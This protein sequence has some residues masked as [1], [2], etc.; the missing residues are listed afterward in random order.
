[1]KKNTLY[2]FLLPV[3]SILLIAAILTSCTKEA[4]EQNIVY[5]SFNRTVT[6]T[7]GT[8]VVDSL[9]INSD[10]YVDFAFGLYKSSAADSAVIAVIGRV[11]NAS[12]VDST[13]NFGSLLL[14]KPL[15][16][17]EVPVA[18]VP[19]KR[20]WY[21]GAFC[22]SKVGT[23]TLGIAGAG[24]KFIPLAVKNNETGKYHY[25]WIRINVS[26]DYVTLKI[27]DGA[28]NFLPEIPVKMGAK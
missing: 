10:N 23:T 11:Q 17:N 22:A 5:K 3:I 21:R 1:M 4:N 16:K 6:S 7:A 26:S 9:D 15:S 28:Y 13:Q 14:S 8:F 24:D 2:T 20:E 25:G 27:I 12:L 19:T 18:L